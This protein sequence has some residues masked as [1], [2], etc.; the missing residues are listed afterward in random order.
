LKTGREQV[1]IIALYEELGSYRAVAALVGCDHKTVKRYVELAGELGQ[2]APTR[3]RTRVTDDYRGLIAERVE[4]TR[5]RI[6][7]RRLLRLLRAAG[8][9]GSERSLRRAVAEE[10]RAFRKR[11]AREG[12]V[13]RPWRSGPGEWLICDW[14][15]A[16]TVETPAGPRRLSFFGSVLGYSRHRQ[17]TFCCSE[18]FPALAMGLAS[19]F[20]QLKWTSPASVDTYGLGGF[21]LD[22]LLF[23][24]QL[25]VVV[26]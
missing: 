26:W 1:E 14:G 18:R 10:K 11:E 8:Y 7:A 6:T 13:F 9:E 21:L 24:Y 3:R 12:R 16:G 5:G 19:N 23:Q 15:Q 22:L 17:L 20:E 4:Q 25:F 2:L